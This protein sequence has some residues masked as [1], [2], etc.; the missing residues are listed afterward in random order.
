MRS[1]CQNVATPLGH[2]LF[3]SCAIRRHVQSCM[4]MAWHAEHLNEQITVFLLSIYKA[5]NYV[6][7]VNSHYLNFL[8]QCVYFLNYDLYSISIFVM[9]FV[10]GSS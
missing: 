9:Q 7:L 6:C 5:I 4:A 8:V 2:P 3:P 1:P 10:Y